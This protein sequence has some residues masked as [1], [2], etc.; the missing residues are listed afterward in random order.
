[1]LFNRHDHVAEH[2]RRSRACDREEVG[3]A[4]RH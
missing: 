4:G 1:M 3:E 2:R